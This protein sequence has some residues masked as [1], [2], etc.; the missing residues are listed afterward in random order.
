LVKIKG[1]S[2][3]LYYKDL[4]V[5]VMSFDRVNYKQNVDGNYELHRYCVK[6]GYTVIGGA[7]RLLKFFEREHKPKYIVSYSDNDYFLGAIYERLK[8]DN[9]GQSTPRYYWYLN[10]EELRRE[11]CMLKHLKVEY[12]ELLQEAINKEA[13]NKEDYVM[14]SLGACK[15]YRSGNTKWEKRY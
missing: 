2:Y 15:V 5:A 7:E 3:G 9:V 4:L 1:G 6:D 13:K 8:F 14:T 12:P 11:Q 10:G